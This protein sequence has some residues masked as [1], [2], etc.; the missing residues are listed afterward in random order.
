MTH[1]CRTAADAAVPWSRKLSAI[2]VIRPV[3]T[4]KDNS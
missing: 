1:P 3:A 4:A 2:M